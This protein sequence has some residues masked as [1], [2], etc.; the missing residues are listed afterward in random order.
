LFDRQARWAVLDQPVCLTYAPVGF[1]RGAAFD[2]M[3]RIR[4][5]AAVFDPQCTPVS[6]EKIVFYQQALSAVVAF[7][8]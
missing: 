6:V 8:V 5:G 7:E 1:R 2:G 4:S 3:A